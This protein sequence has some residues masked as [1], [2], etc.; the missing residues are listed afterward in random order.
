MLGSAEFLFFAL[1]GSQLFNAMSSNYVIKW[2]VVYLENLAGWPIFSY[3]VGMIMTEYSLISKIWESIFL[4]WFPL[5]IL[6]KA[7]VALCVV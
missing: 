2:T 3:V 1:S 6:A 4:N 5:I 7:S